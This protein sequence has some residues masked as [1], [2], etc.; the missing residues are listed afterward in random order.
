[1]RVIWKA[2]IAAAFAIAAV[3][4]AQ[5]NSRGV[6]FT[7]GGDLEAPVPGFHDAYIERENLLYCEC[8]GTFPE[9]TVLGKHSIR[10]LAE[11]ISRANFIQQQR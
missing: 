8:H 4:V 11:D 5:T 10:P 2:L 3:A 9:G 6:V 7:K 1:M